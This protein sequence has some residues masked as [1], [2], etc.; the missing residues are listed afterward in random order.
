MSTEPVAERAEATS[1]ESPV[2]EDIVVAK[3]VESEKLNGSGMMDEIEVEEEDAG[4]EYVSSDDDAESEDEEEDSGSESE[5]DVNDNDNT[6]EHESYGHTDI[7]DAE[8]ESTSVYVGGESPYQAQVEEELQRQR[9]QSLVEP[10]GDTSALSWADADG[11]SPNRNSASR[12]PSPIQRSAFP[13]PSPASSGLSYDASEKQRWTL[14]YAGGEI[15]SPPGDTTLEAIDYHLS[16]TRSSSSAAPASSATPRNAP[17]P[18]H[19]HQ[20]NQDLTVGSYAD[21]TVGSIEYMDVELS[22]VAGPSFIADVSPDEDE[23]FESP[24]LA[25]SREEE[26]EDSFLESPDSMG[27][28]TAQLGYLQPEDTLNSLYNVYNDMPPSPKAAVALSDPSTTPSSLR[29]RVFTPPPDKTPRF[30]RGSATHTPPPVPSSPATS[31]GSF[32]KGRVTPSDSQYAMSERSAGRQSPDASTSK[33]IPFGFRGSRSSSR[34][35]LSSSSQK[36]RSLPQLTTTNSASVEDLNQP[37]S[38]TPP[39]SASSAGSAL[40]PLRLSVLLQSHSNAHAHSRS[41]SS[42]APSTMTSF[43]IHDRAHSIHAT[44]PS[45][46]SLM[47]ANSLSTP[48]SAPHHATFTGLDDESTR[49]PSIFTEASQLTEDLN[50]LANFGSPI[51]APISAPASTSHWPVH[52]YQQQQVPQHSYYQPQVPHPYHEERASS[53]NVPEPILELSLLPPS[54]SPPPPPHSAPVVHQQERAPST[55]KQSTPAAHQRAP[56]TVKQSTFT[57]EDTKP[58]LMFAIA[59]DDVEQV[60]QVL[61]SGEADPNECVGPQAALAFALSN[62]NLTNKLDIVKML[63]AFG[64][65]P[66]VLQDGQPSGLAPAEGEEQAPA[67]NIVMDAMDPATRYYVE[68]A[69]AAQTRRTSK[70]INR[71]F[72]RPL[73]RVQY[74]LIG[75]DRALEELFRLLSIHS[76]QAIASPLVVMFSGPS[77]HG[78]SLLARKFGSLLDIPTHTVN[79]VT[80]RSQDDLWESYSVSP[81][82]EPTNCTLAEFLVNNEG[83]RCVVVLDEIEKVVNEKILW[84][85]LMPWEHGRCSLEA[86]SRHID[87][88]KVIWLCTSNIGQDLI[89]NHWDSR[90]FTQEVSSRQEFL[91]LVALLRPLVSERLG[92]SV[93]S[94]ITSVLPFVP[95]SLEEK[96]AMSAEAIFQLGGEDAI[97]L[98]SDNIES[99]VQLALGHYIPEEGARSLHRAISNHLVDMI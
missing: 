88:R 16:P 65:D 35:S 12:S 81:I 43:A 77:G 83:K 84:S 80:P 68:R 71:S 23:S 21:A 14:D 5:S 59:S 87:V 41:Q 46:S 49:P 45:Q 15:S 22:P 99:L 86:R 67:Q 62:E 38:A 75:Q 52:Q 85:L 29:E 73:A 37:P 19:Q 13:S 18:E 24:A 89:F 76:R 78:K 26:V 31:F 96:R 98:S 32:S 39:P 51:S 90:E 82:E 63:L 48:R 94:R 61:E 93:L 55:I 72:F 79:M 27:D 7:W 25:Y 34:L 20:D 91:E 11:S 64:A 30:G 4:L 95:F 47:I 28:S 33:R 74:D 58:A 54:P 9:S 3:E 8:R 10:A 50:H 1:R 53:S 66:K 17:L 57:I 56:S 97:G 60:R 70:L 40:R 92:A 44:S 6:Q 36:Q 42:T 69:K 2:V